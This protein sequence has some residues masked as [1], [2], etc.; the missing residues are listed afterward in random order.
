MWPLDDL[1]GVA[2]ALEQL[3]DDTAYD[4]IEGKADL[5]ESNLLLLILDWS[6]CSH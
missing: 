5:A 3:L 2:L 6:L 4:G 1:D